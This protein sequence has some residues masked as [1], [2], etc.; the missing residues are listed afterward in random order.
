MAKEI[1]T[2]FPERCPRLTPRIHCKKTETV[3]RK[4]NSTFQIITGIP[5]ANLTVNYLNQN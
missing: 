4:R 2:E 1:G 3:P 5:N